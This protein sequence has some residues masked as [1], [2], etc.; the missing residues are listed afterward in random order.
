MENIRCYFALRIFIVAAVGV[1]AYL[2]QQQAQAMQQDSGAQDVGGGFFSGMVDTVNSTITNITASVP[3]ALKDA[4]VQAFLALVRVGEGTSDA[5]GYSRLFGGA[6]FASFAKHPGV[7]VPFGS[8]YSTAAGAY[9]ILA[10]TWAEISAQYALPDFS[11]AS[12]DIAAVGLIKRRG[13]LGDVL[14]G[15]MATAIQKCNREW[16]SLP[17]SPYGQ[18]TLTME[19]ATL[20][21]AAQGV[22]SIES[23]AA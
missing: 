8:S 19:R 22:Y 6:Q 17:G 13:A 7:K 12:Q 3:D 21:L 11:P 9:Q 15:R 18:P 2:A 4:N 10:S 20:I 23:M 1:L 5:A 14:A 16:A